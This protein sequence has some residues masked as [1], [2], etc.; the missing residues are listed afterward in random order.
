VEAGMSIIET[1]PRSAAPS[2]GPAAARVAG[3]QGSEAAEWAG[4][5]HS[6]WIRPHYREALVFGNPIQV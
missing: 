3:S 2:G 6:G 5:R 1:A 4:G